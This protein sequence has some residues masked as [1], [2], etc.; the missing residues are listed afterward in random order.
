MPLR[1]FHDHLIFIVLSI[2]NFEQIARALF[3]R[4]M[5]RVCAGIQSRCKQHIYRKIHI[6]PSK[7]IRVFRQTVARSNKSI[8]NNTCSTFVV[9]RVDI[10]PSFSSIKRF[11]VPKNGR[12]THLS[13]KLEVFAESS[14]RDC[15]RCWWASIPA[16]EYDADCFAVSRL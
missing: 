13:R 2:I 4:N 3:P 15:C 10:F 5:Q 14:Y 16:C 6:F 11:F 9:P 1:Y 12:A 7:I 8:T